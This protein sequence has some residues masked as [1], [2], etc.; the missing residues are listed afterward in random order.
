MVRY[1]RHALREKNLIFSAATIAKGDCAGGR[2]EFVA[3]L[4]AAGS[5]HHNRY[6]GARL[7]V[8]GLAFQALPAALAIDLAVGALAAIL[9]KDF[10]YTVATVRW[11]NLSFLALDPLASDRRSRTT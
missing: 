8:A 11:H 4:L 6:R 2:N 3:V 1:R 5:A 10:G 9:G 7:D